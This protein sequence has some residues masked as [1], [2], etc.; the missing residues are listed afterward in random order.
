LLRGR[1]VADYDPREFGISGQLVIKAISKSFGIKGEEV[2]KRFRKV[3]DL[4]EIAEEFASKK[5][6]RALFALK[7]SVKKVFDNLQ[8]VM[9]FSGKG[10]VEKKIGLVSELLISASGKETKYIV[11]TLLSDLRVGVA[12]GILRDAVAK[13]FYPEES[14]EM[15][16]KVEEV[17]GLANDWAL[18]FE[19][20]S[21]GKK[22]LEKISIIPG[23]PINVMLPVKVTE[24]KEAFRICGKPVAIEHKYDGFRMIISKK[25]KE[26]KL[27]TRRLENVT[28]QFPDPQL[29]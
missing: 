26:I 14:E 12:G 19:S 11:R 2:V 22:A 17:Y 5:R 16:K 3:G 4:G 29:S 24:I 28:K 8:K 13:A 20:A 7:L 18:V 9:E 27:F 15:S 6:Q 1:V 25:G 23:R 21:K 10:A